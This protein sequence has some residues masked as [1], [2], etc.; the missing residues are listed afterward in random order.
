MRTACEIIE[1]TILR[2]LS[3]RLNSRFSLVRQ[4]DRER[5][6]RPPME[7][8]G[9]A[10]E[11]ELGFAPLLTGCCAVKKTWVAVDL[12]HH[13]RLAA[14]RHCAGNALPQGIAGGAPIPGEPDTGPYLELPG[15]L[16]QKGHG[17]PHCPAAAHQDGKDARE[18]GL[19][20]NIAGQ[21][22]T[23]VHQGTELSGLAR[24][25]TRRAGLFLLPGRCHHPARAMSGRPWA[26]RLMKSPLGGAGRDRRLI[27]VVSES[28]NTWGCRS[29]SRG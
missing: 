2:N 27:K 25:G 26:P 14:L 6:Y 13:D 3:S 18:A 24:L 11:A 12:R 17:A 5:A 21:R 8:D 16:I 1:A 15:A 10:H 4:F 9:D 19:Q 29:C 7:E 28:A 23:H 20:V 22:L